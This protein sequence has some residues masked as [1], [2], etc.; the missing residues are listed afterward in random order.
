MGK[1][2]IISVSVAAA[3]AVLVTAAVVRTRMSDA[4]ETYRNVKVLETEGTADLTRGEET[5]SVYE[6]M[7][8]RGGDILS[9]GADGWV[10]LSL[11]DDKY[12]IVE[13]SSEVEF[14]LEGEKDNG[15]IR[16]HLNAGAIYNEIENPIADGDSYEIETPDGVMAVRGT[17]FRVAIEN[18]E[19]G[20]WRLTTISVFE[21]TV[22]IRVDNSDGEETIITAGEEAVIEKYFGDEETSEKEAR[23]RKSGGDIDVENLP[24]YLIARLGNLLTGDDEEETGDGA[25]ERDED[26]EEEDAGE[27]DGEETEDNAI[28]GTV[29]GSSDSG[30]GSTGGLNTAG[31]SASEPEPDT[32]A[33]VDAN[34]GTKSDAEDNANAGTK[35]DA[36]DNANAGTEADSGTEADA[37]TEADSGTEANAGTE[38]DSGTEANAGTESDTGTESDSGT[39]TDTG[40]GTVVAL[41]SDDFTVDTSDQ[42]YTGSAITPSVTVSNTDLTSADY[43]VSYSEN[44]EA[45]TATI[46]ITGTGSYTGTLT[47]T[48]SIT[49]QSVEI[50]TIESTVYNPVFDS[51]YS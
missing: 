8:I 7:V 48:F 11:D 29:R 47:Y 14:E 23:L 40:T 32:G 51:W 13:P 30:T 16:L 24:D 28:E 37:G 10:D 19:D 31:G 27:N 41:T 49:K 18:T 42:V 26:S 39:E 21:G 15:A 12:A 44:T 17:K 35:S 38:A 2:V 46:T 50:P 45:G 4:D 5:M 22:H 6:Q 33:G 9:T 1:P 36:E 25:S 3:A 20:L 34:V 43:T